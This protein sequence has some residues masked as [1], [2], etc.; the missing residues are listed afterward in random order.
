[1]KEGKFVKIQDGIIIKRSSLSGFRKDK[2]DPNACHYYIALYDSK[3][4]SYSMHPTSH[5]IDPSKVTDIKRK[6][7]ILMNIKGA[8]GPS[9]VYKQPRKKDIHGQYFTDKFSKYETVGCL[10]DYQQKRLK[11]FINSTKRY[12]NANKKKRF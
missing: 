12:K 7:A 10:T 8:P 1:M 4:K 2:Y 3:N 11:R 5:Y 6:R 9:T